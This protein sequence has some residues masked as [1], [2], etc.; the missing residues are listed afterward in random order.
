MS[1]PIKDLEADLA[2]IT[3]LAQSGSLD[4]AKA[5]AESLSNM[6]QDDKRLKELL[7]SVER[8]RLNQRL[9]GIRKMLSAGD[10]LEAEAKAKALEEAHGDNERLR[11]LQ[12]SIEKK[13][14]KVLP[15]QIIRLAE[16][17]RFDEAEA[18]VARFNEQRKD[19]PQF[20]KAVKR[21]E[22]R[23]HRTAVEAHRKTIEQGRTLLEA[24][25]AAAALK[26]MRRPDD[27]T[28]ERQANWVRLYVSAL[29]QTGAYQEIVDLLE[30]HLAE[31]GKLGPRVQDTL[32]EAYERLDRVEDAQ[33]LYRSQL[34]APEV[35]IEGSLRSALSRAEDFRPVKV[36][37]RS[38]PQQMLDR[39]WSLADQSKWNRED[40]TTLVR[41]GL[42]AEEIL[43]GLAFSTG[44]HAEEMGEIVH[45]HDYDGLLDLSRAGKPCVA[46]GTHL[47]PIMAIVPV[48][49]HY[50]IPAAMLTGLPMPNEF[51]TDHIKFIYTKRRSLATLREIDK[52]VG[53]GRVLC[54]AVDVD[55]GLGSGDK[56]YAFEIFGHKV[57]VFSMVTRII[58]RYK[59]PSFV[60]PML[61]KDDGI[62]ATAIT[63]PEP[64]EDEDQDAFAA[65][66]WQA[67]MDHYLKILE[68][69][70]RNLTIFS[71]M[72][73]RALNKSQESLEGARDLPISIG[74]SLE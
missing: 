7:A 9:T 60:T 27:V 62:D 71:G 19:D 51:Q 68:G 32:G 57:R 53:D 38:F 37:N 49:K 64:R 41:R 12:A 31:S 29:A 63:L 58:H 35:A 20:L 40:W 61:F 11:D 4:E 24:G 39:L 3:Q 44:K 45:A 16:Q 69:D 65:R 18:L 47:G 14:L 25:D 54:M 26:I 10:L 5:K 72:V 55:E 2:E 28:S 21:L 67:Y 6:H 34:F 13:L 33:N 46:V 8:K 73:Y 17:G 23:K 36:P 70:P 30:P 1:S 43:R 15:A 48:M 74:K 50:A 59:L 56:G 52:A 66:W 42:A 22:R